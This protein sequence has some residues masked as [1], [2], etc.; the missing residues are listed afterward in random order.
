SEAEGMPLA[1]MEAMAKGLPVAATAVNGILEELGPTGK[2][3]PNPCADHQAVVFGLAET[4]ET[5]AADA[6][7]REA[8]GEACRERARNLFREERMI[9][10]S[11]AVIERALLPPGDYV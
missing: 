9:E 10:E 1:V 5:W 11:L 6:D 3:L 8:V 7:L 2:L 4:I